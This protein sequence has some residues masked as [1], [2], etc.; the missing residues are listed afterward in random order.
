MRVRKMIMA[1]KM[2]CSTAKKHIQLKIKK[3]KRGRE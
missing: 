1:M 3:T 2:I